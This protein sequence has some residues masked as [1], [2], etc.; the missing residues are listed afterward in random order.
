[1][2]TGS[3]AVTGWAIDDIGVARVT[4]CRNPVAGEV[5]E[6]SRLRARADLSRRR[7][8]IDDARPDLEA[9]SPTTPLQLSRRLGIPGADQ[10]AAEQGNGAFTF[11]V[12]AFDV[13]GH[14]TAIGARNIAAQ[15]TT[16]NEPFGTIDTPGQGETIG[17]TNLRELRLGAVARASGRPARRRPRH[18]D[19]RRRRRRQPVLLD[20]PH[21][22]LDG[23]LSEP[24]P[25]STPRWA[26]SASIPP[27][28]PTA[29]T[30]SPGSSP[31]AAA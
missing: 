6:P 15:N 8:V 5:G 17:G 12:H 31:T 19:H 13:E 28:T 29:C 7:G 26:C 2:V 23:D 18:R 4:I 24:I 10:H 20:S 1:M 21:R 9:T 3:V 27:S 22:P 16:A 30:P 25:A 11:Y 14:R